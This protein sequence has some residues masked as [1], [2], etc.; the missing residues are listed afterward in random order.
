MGGED[1]DDQ[2]MIDQVAR[3]TSPDLKARATFE[4]EAEGAAT[5][6]PIEEASAEDLRE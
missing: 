2:E 6:K 3:Q 5:D 1:V 4:R